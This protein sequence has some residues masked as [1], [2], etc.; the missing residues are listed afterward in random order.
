MHHPLLA[1]YCKI[2]VVLLLALTIPPFTPAAKQ[3]GDTAL[4]QKIF[5]ENC[6]RCHGE[7]GSGNT[8]FGKALGAADLRSADIQK[9]SDTQF[10]TLIEKGKRNMPPFEGTLSKVEI[11]DLIAYVREIGKKQS[12]GKRQ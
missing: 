9:K 7:N 6:Q 11:N 4:G 3:R 12:D 10:Y 2:S 1:K 8:T 5:V